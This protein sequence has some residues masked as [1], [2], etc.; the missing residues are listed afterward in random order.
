MRQKDKEFTEEAISGTSESSKV[1]KILAQKE[2]EL[3]S[4]KSESRSFQ[5]QIAALQRKLEVQNSEIENTKNQLRRSLT[6][7]KDEQ[8][9][10]LSRLQI[11]L[12]D[13]KTTRVD[14][15]E[16]LDDAQH[17]SEMLRLQLNALKNENK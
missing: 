8:Q 17:E 13:L 6:S 15:L 4:A 5:A 2:I 10:E 11:M 12:L 1:R 16:Q 14:L 3:E 7:D 9:E